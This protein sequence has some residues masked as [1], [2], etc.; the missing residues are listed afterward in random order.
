[1]RTTTGCLA[2]VAL[3]V[4]SVLA[5]ETASGDRAVLRV[6]VPRAK[7]VTGAA[8]TLGALCV[9]RCDD[10]A[11]QDDA[12]DV[13]M[14]RAPFA[15]ETIVIDRATI[16]SRL[17]AAGIPPAKVAFSGAGS[18][19]LSRNERVFASKQVLSAARAY[20]D[21][22]P[23]GPPGSGYRLVRKTGRLT[24]ASS[25]KTTLRVRAL[26]DTPRGFVKLEVVAMAGKRRL[27]AAEVLFKITYP[28]RQAVAAEPIRTGAVLTSR[29][30]R[31]RTVWLDQPA[32]KD[33]STPY[34]MEAAR[35]IAQGTV[36]TAGMIR[37]RK[38][39]IVVRRKEVVTMV[40]R[41]PG[42]MIQGKGQA[43]QDGRPGQYIKVRNATSNRIVIAKVQ[44]DGT[45]TPS[46]ETH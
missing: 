10:D 26:P 41:G 13:K 38:L 12:D 42:F 4:S 40:I 18:V 36:I 1:M 24:V 2:A 5:G 11:L 6:Y 43:L 37:A 23:P 29:N 33:V 39:E 30:T 27:A 22:H 25:T 7:T 31:L 9:L 16:L 46:M 19:T 44:Y 28:H 8:L 34:G 3:L 17:A 45:V 20:L 15:E 32:P 35:N 21:E 14:G